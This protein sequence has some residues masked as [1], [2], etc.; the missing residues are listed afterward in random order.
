MNGS[1]ASKRAIHPR[2]CGSFIPVTVWHFL[3]HLSYIY[4][5]V[6]YERYAKN[7]KYRNL[8]SKKNRNNEI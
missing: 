4:D 8:F 6:I 5:N 2:P 1:F 3:F 7:I